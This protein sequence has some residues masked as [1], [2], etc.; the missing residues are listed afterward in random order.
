MPNGTDRHHRVLR[1][2]GWLHL[3]CQRA[4]AVH[5]GAR[6]RRRGVHRERGLQ[7]QPRM[8]DLG[9]LH[10]HSECM[11]P[12]RHLHRVR[13]RHVRSRPPVQREHLRA[14]RHHHARRD[15][16]PSGLQIP[17]TE[18]YVDL[19]LKSDLF[20]V[21]STDGSLRIH[22]WPGLGPRH[23]H[24]SVG[25]ARLRHRPGQRRR[26]LDV[27]TDR[28]PLLRP[29]HAAE[30]SGRDDPGRRPTGEWRCRRLLD[31]R[32]RRRRLQLRQ[33][34]VLRQHGRHAPQPAGRRP[35]PRR[36]TP[37]ATGRWPATVACS[38]S[39]T[40]SSTAAPGASA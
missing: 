31:Q 9:Q 16:K 36:T 25:R 15:R 1:L 10:G 33:R 27:P 3:E 38:A 4:V 26:E 2:D 11:A 32:G 8:V 40:R 28:E 20:T 12:D 5:R 35:W 29:R 6:R 39:A 19:G 14:G 22:Q 30:P 21:T 18:F 13:W 37:P 23:R 24:G 17:G 7:P 34:A